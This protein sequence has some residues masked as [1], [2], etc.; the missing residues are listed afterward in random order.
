MLP[1]SASH[2]G[3]DARTDPPDKASAFLTAIFCGFAALLP[4]IGVVAPKGLVLLLLFT[5]ILAI[6]AYWLARKKSPLPDRR[7]SIALAL[8]LAWCAITST[9]GLDLTRSLELVLRVAVLFAAGAI[10]FTVAT[11][12]DAAARV[13]I[14]RWLV[15]GFVLILALMVVEVVLDYP[16][17]RALSGARAGK[18]N[19]FL[20]RGAVAMALIVWPVMAHLWGRGLGWKTLAIPVALGIGSF[21][22]ESAAATVGIAVG[23]ATMLVVASHRM[24]GRVVAMGAA[25]LSF[26]GMPLAGLYMHD[27]G[28]HRAD[29]LVYS[30]Q[31]RVEIWNF[32]V[33]RIAEKPLLGWGFDASRHIQGLYTLSAETGRGLLP[34]HPHSAPLQIMLELGAIGAVI[35]LALLWLIVKRLDDISGRTRDLGYALFIAALAIGCVSYGTWQNWWLALI[36]SVAIVTALTA[37]Q[38]ARNSAIADDP[39]PQSKS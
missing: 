24:A 11:A 37:V 10:L 15:G 27:H 7:L 20:N 6:P 8:L 33:E 1:P 23:T 4:I 3:D 18:E 13:R 35:A 22:L 2:G 29:W 32:A 17:I 31:H 38:G 16:M 5:A 36:I 12:L 34:L 39:R 26:V 14:G 25:I 28:W 21:F 9:W 19:V 30:A